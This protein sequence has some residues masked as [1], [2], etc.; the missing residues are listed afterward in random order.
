M[1]MILGEFKFQ[2]EGLLEITFIL[3]FFLTYN[4]E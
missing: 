4:I 1:A 3:L 2:T